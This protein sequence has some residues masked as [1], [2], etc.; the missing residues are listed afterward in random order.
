MLPVRR[1][2]APSRTMPRV[3]CLTAGRSLYFALGYTGIPNH[4]KQVGPD[5]ARGSVWSRTNSHLNLSLKISTPT[6]DGD[7]VSAPPNWRGLFTSGNTPCLLS[8]R[9][10]RKIW[11]RLHLIDSAP[12]PQHADDISQVARWPQSE[13]M[14]WVP[15]VATPAYREGCES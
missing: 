9:S 1:L 15:E 7:P 2:A 8:F 3:R 4:D 10:A 11:T 13:R 5:S 6:E 14:P 12:D